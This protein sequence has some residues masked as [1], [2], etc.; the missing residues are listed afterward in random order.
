MKTRY[1]SEIEAIIAA[2]PDLQ[3][4]REV[5]DREL[6]PTETLVEQVLVAVDIYMRDSGYESLSR[7]SGK[8][9][10]MS[11]DERLP[12]EDGYYWCYLVECARQCHPQQAIQWKDGSWMTS[13]VVSHWRPLMLAPVTG[14]SR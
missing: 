7:A 12:S 4:F 3:R 10:W 8:V 2:D 13:W 9:D 14:V 6:G 1:S 5:D 11:V